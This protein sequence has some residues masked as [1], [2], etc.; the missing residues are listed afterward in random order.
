MLSLVQNKECFLRLP[1]NPP[2]THQ[3]PPFQ[4]TPYDCGSHG[5]C[6]PSN[7]SSSTTCSSCTCPDGTTQVSDTECATATSCSPT[8]CTGN[9]EQCNLV[10]GEAVCSCA[11]GYTGTDC[12]MLTSDPC[13]TEPCLQNGD[14]TSDSNGYTCTCDSG[15][16]GEQCQYSGDP[17]SDYCSNGGTCVLVFSETTPYCECPFEYYGKTCQT[18]RSIQTTYVGCYDDSS[19]TFSDYH[20]YS[21]SGITTGDDCADALVTY[22]KANPTSDYV[23]STMSGTTGQC[24]FSTTNTLTTAPSQG[25]LGGLLSALLATCSY[26]SLSSGSASVYSLNDLCA[27]EPCGDAETGECYQ[28]SASAYS[29]L[30]SPLKTGTTC[31]SDATLTPCNGI[32]CGVTGT[33]EI[34]DDQIGYYCKC[35]NT[36]QTTE[37]VSDPCLIDNPCLYGGTCRDLGNGSY[38]CDCL[39]L[40]CQTNCST[41]NPCYINKCVNGGTCSPTYNLL[42]STFTCECDSSW[43]GEYC[44]EERFYCDETPCKNNATCE[45]IIGPP[46]SYNC[47]CTPQWQGQNC[48]EDVNECENDSTLCKTKDSGAICVNTN[49]SYYCE[50]SADMF[51]TQCLY[52][53]FLREVLS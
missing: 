3:N 29:C 15:Y 1:E 45:D 44:E 4:D 21:T 31:S 35:A 18:S 28:T 41:F 6:Y 50:C 42:D 30:C 20:V 8:P 17:C 13:S 2:K 11:D 23:I 36:N 22:R 33:C 27:S 24:M 48:T 26:A 52:S 39:N 47:T 16:Y 14:C 7:R 38:S 34:T 43:K 12:D 40:Y 51:G 32:D 19:A 25:L 46:N 10:E 37:C 53:E 49:G 5:Y 9:N